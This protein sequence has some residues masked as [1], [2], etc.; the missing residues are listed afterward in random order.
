M[1]VVRV[2]EPSILEPDMPL[3][4]VLLSRPSYLK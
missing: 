2:L 1:L 4:Q 3:P